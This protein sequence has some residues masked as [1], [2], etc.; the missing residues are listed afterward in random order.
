MNEMMYLKQVGDQ[1]ICTNYFGLNLEKKRKYP[2]EGSFKVD[3]NIKSVYFNGKK[4]Y[5]M[6]S[7][8]L[9]LVF[10]NM[11]VL[12]HEAFKELA[13]DLKFH[14]IKYCLKRIGSNVNYYI[15][16][17]IDT[18]PKL[19]VIMS[20]IAAG[21]ISLS[22]IT[23]YN[24]QVLR[25]SAFTND[26]KASYLFIDDE[27][28]DTISIT[29]SITDSS[30]DVSSVVESTI[31][32]INTSNE[33]SNL[34]EENNSIDEIEAMRQETSYNEEDLIVS[35]DSKTNDYV[36]IGNKDFYSGELYNNLVTVMN[37]T[38]KTAQMN[39]VIN[40]YISNNLAGEM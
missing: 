28:P 8:D 15:R 34:I 7:S 31:S 23:N 3:N 25:S 38:N 29:E 33:T 6:L 20:V 13:E 37:N 26:S 11:N 5:V 30:T 24:S 39:Q 14:Y 16:K 22:N 2:I 12:K 10:K 35:K 36:V 21:A 17:V 4:I 40:D 1:V 32:G 18:R 27:L 9:V 19:S